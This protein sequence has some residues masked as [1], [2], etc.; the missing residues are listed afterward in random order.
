MKPAPQAKV[1]SSTRL[2]P[3]SPV[4]SMTASAPVA[5][6][7]TSCVVMITRRRSMMSASEPAI[8]PNSRNGTVLADCT[9]ATISAEGV[10]VA[11]THAAI[12]ACM[13]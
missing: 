6:S 10:S 7:M 5:E 12:A 4:I 13:V 8:S 11:I 1:S 3:T 9:M 2:G